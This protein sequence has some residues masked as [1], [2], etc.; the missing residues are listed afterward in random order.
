MTESDSTYSYPP[1]EMRAYF[2]TIHIA[3]HS[4]AAF[5]ALLPS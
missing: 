2:T 5:Y 3:M 1:R 4:H